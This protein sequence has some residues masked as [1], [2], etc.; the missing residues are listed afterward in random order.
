MSN[1]KNGTAFEREFAEL[2][3]EN[4]FW[5][6][7]LADNANG[8]PFDVIAVRNGNAYVF[9]CK[10]CQGER[11]DLRRIEENQENAMELW[12]ETGNSTGMFAVRFR[13]RIYLLPYKVLAV[14]RDGGTTASVTEAIAR[15]MGQ[16]IE[17]WIKNREK[18]EAAQW[19]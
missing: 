19:R 9:D 3:A 6:H 11:F 7:C 13:T 12:S 5:A 8:Q 4:G 2:L 1:K 18:L 10:D 15:R 17:R 16:P 14:L